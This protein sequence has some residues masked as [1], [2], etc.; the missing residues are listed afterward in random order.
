MKSLEV[1]I[2]GGGVNVQRF[3]QPQYHDQVPLSK[4]LNLQLLP[5]CRSINGCSLLRVCV[6]SVCL[7]TAVCVHFGWVNAE[8]EFRV[9]VTILGCMSLHSLTNPNPSPTPN[10]K[11]ILGG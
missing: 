11:P 5:G 2:V 6:H 10:L 3:L 1:G 7:F 4:A 8:H 9:R